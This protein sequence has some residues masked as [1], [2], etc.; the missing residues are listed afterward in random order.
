VGAEERTSG[1][2]AR[3]WVV[4]SSWGQLV[5]SGSVWVVTAAMPYLLPRFWQDE[6]QRQRSVSETR[7]KRLEALER[8]LSMTETARNQHKIDVNIRDL[9]GELKRIVHEFADP[10]VLSLEAL[11][12]WEKGKYIG[13]PGRHFTVPVNEANLYRRLRKS[14]V[15]SFM[16][17]YIIF[18]LTMLITHSNSLNNMVIH[19]LETQA[20]RSSIAVHRVEV[21]WAI[22]WF[23]VML[24][25]V[26][27]ASGWFERR[28]A[29][30]ALKTLRANV[31]KRG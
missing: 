28:L 16:L 27:S 5:V 22:T 30:R 7:I 24:S 10:A 12:E 25:L 31:R 29:E 4:G 21:I 20:Q 11:E 18:T 3:F 17:F 9:Q 6:L 13:D 26:F 19:W 8:A 23:A 14:R 1:D 15:I 2:G